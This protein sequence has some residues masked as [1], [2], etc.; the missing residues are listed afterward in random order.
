M[1]FQTWLRVEGEQ[2][3]PEITKMVE[4]WCEK[5][6]D[7][8]W[9][10]TCFLDSK[11]VNLDE[12]VGCAAQ[13]LGGGVYEFEEGDKASCWVL[14]LKDGTFQMV[15]DFLGAGFA[16]REWLFEISRGSN[17]EECLEKAGAKVDTTV[18]QNLIRDRG[19][20]GLQL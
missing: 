10:M 17:F 1:D 7:A 4:K 19:S 9:A 16:T 6:L 12:L 15:Q 14:Q 11:V 18:I 8:E 20:K 2:L 3:P 13:H 5:G